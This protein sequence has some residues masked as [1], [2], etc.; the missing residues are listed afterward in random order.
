[1]TDSPSA[2]SGRFAIYYAPRPDSRHWLAGSQWLGRCAVRQE[3]LP[4]AP[5]AGLEPAL[6]QQLTAAPRRY[7]WH[8]TLKAPFQLAPGVSLA[9]LQQQLRALAADLQPFDMPALQVVLLDDFLALVPDPLAPQNAAIQALAQRCV[10]DL[11]PL[12]APLGSAELARRRQAALTPQQ[13]ALMLRWGYPHVFDYF[14]FHLSLTGPL[15]ALSAADRQALQAAAQAHFAALPAGRFDSLALFHEASP[16]AD[17]VLLEH[18][19][20]GP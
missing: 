13:D 14:R 9:A 6:L 4:Q 1:M 10:M 15:G 19:G 18:V 16:G 20:L 17:F 8:A 12:A 11:Q 7:G 3:A 2:A 5:M